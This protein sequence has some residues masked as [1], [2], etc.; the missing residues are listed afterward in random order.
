[1]NNMLTEK[2]TSISQFKTSP[3]QAIEDSEGRPFAILNRDKVLGYMVSP[4]RMSELLE[5]E[6][7][8]YLRPL[9]EE[10]SNDKS[11]IRET[12]LEDLFA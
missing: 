8:N 5:A 2:W 12:S 9:I 4:E 1:M 3:T 10:R 7:N 6:E 11:Q